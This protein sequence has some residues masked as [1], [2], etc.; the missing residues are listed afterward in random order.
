MSEQ[1]KLD[2]MPGVAKMIMEYEPQPDPLEQ[3]KAQLEIEKLK[4]EIAERNSRAAENQVD[5]RLKNANAD[6]AEARARDY[7]SMADKKDKEFL[8]SVDGGSHI[9]EMDKIYAKE[10]AKAMHAKPSVVKQ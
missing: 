7:H 10:D 4:A 2:K 3:E 6:L 1:L 9:Q 8:D 5:M